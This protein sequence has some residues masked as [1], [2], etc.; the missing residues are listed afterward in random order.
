MS[1][2]KA[3]IIAFYLP[4]FHPIRENDQW[5]GEGFTEWTNVKKARPLFPGHL[6]PRIPGEL[7]YYDL[8][9]AEVR[10]MQAALAQSHG[11]EGFCYWHYWFAG[12]RLLNLP[13]DEMLKSG[14]P[15]LPFCLGWANE[16]WTGVWHGA[17]NRIL[18][19]QTYPGAEDDRR[20]FEFLLSAF[21][22]SRYIR[23]DGKPLLVIYKPTRMPNGRGRFDAWRNLA[24]RS[25]LPGLHI[26][27]IDLDGRS[28]AASCGL[29]AVIVSRFGLTSNGALARRL[30][31]TYWG[32]RRRLPRPYL[33]IVRY[34]DAV[35]HM[36]PDMRASASHNYPC[37]VPNWD[38]TPRS[39]QRGMVV[40]GSSPARF[41]AH[42]EQ[43]IAS[44]Q[45]FPSEHRLVFLKSWNEWAEG[46]FVEPDIVYGRGY[47]EAVRAANAGGD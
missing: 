47:L 31:R 11:I 43:A 27:G 24:S 29:D 15:S 9:S 22:D 44:V 23:V 39:G 41:Q 26:V 38:N 42:L 45:A 16:S 1:P 25:G 13:L 37:V 10:A 12:K 2:S 6:Q 20:H 46:N 21:Q 7:G 40:V 17:P 19:E 33:R 18:I 5:W 14:E 32:I 36:L 3:R 8:R 30:E 35:R 28:V 34:E 4:Q